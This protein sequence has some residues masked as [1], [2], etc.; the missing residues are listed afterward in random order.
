[1]SITN[2]PLLQSVLNNLDDSNIKLVY[3]DWL[4]QEGKQL[5]A[6]AWRYVAT[7]NPSY[8]NLFYIWK[9]L[10]IYF[11]YVLYEDGIDNDIFIYLT[12]PSK[13]VEKYC[14]YQ[15]KTYLNKK[16]AI[17]DLVKAYIAY[18]INE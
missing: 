6:E 10:S 1:M 5:E 13:F 7:K 14:S 9:R 3:S 8:E 12:Y 15:Y 17:L 2:N 4:E 18:K 11:G 16:D